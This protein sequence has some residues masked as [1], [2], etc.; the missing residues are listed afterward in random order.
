MFETITL[1][2]V[3]TF[4]SPVFHRSSVVQRIGPARGYLQEEAVL[5]DELHDLA[6]NAATRA[7]LQRLAL[8][9]RRKATRLILAVR[10]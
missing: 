5:A 1:P 6:L 2:N 8:K 9:A 7:A 4:T 10:S 3:P